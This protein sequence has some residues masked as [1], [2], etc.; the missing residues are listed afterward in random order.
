MSGRKLNLT[1]IEEVRSY[2]IDNNPKHIKVGVFD[3]DGVLRGKFISRDKFLSAIDNGYGFCNALLGWDVSDTL[4]DNSEYT[5]WHTGFPDANLRIIPESG[6]ILPFQNETLFFASE[7]VG[8]AEAI[9]PRGV[10]RRVLQ[11][12]SDM[13]FSIKA[14]MEFEFFMFRESSDTVTEKDFK[15][16][17]T[18]SPGSFSYSVL[19]SLVQE[20][21]YQEILDTFDSIGIDLEGLHAETGPGVVETAIAVDSALGMADKAS[22]FKAFMKILAQNRGLMATFMAKWNED[23]SGQSGHT[24][25]SLW[26]NDG[27]PLFYDASAEHSMSEVMRH[28]LGGQLAYLRDFAAMV[29]PNINS[30]SRLTPGYWAPTAATWGIDNRTVGIRVIPGSAKSQRL[31]YRVPGSDVN[32][33]LSMAAAIGSGLLGIEK[34]IDPG[35][36]SVGNAYA[37]EVPESR[38]LPSNLETSAVLFGASAEAKDLFGE[39]FVRHFADSRSFEARQFARAVTDWELRRYFEIL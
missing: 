34:K 33:Y 6:L 36:I 16:L 21:L 10:L 28:F 29:A 15:N 25:M 26:S 9:C 32:P 2:V 23:L 38:R 8:T 4:Y 30:Y 13:G 5:G 22:I 24:H 14:A 39:A 17:R 18:L 27:R 1:S 35:A 7:F 3:I 31:E 11:R 37:K 12:A 20:G 19:R